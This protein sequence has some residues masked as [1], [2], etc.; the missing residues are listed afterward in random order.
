MSTRHRCPVAQLHRR[1]AGPLGH[2]GAGQAF[3]ALLQRDLTVLKKNVGEFV[4]RTIIQPFLLVF[5]FLYVFPQIGQAVGGASP[6]PSRH[7]PANR[8]SPAC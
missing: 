6:T 8:R 3:L 5:V 1:Q 7:W 4:G 2:G